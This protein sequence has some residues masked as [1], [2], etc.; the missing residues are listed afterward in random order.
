[1]RTN[2]LAALLAFGFSA[3]G[4]FTFYFPDQFFNLLP[5]YYGSFNIHFVK[6][7]GISFL[8]SGLLLTLSLAYVKWRIPLTLGGILFVLL[9]GL[10]HIQMLINGMASTFIDLA[11]EVIVIIFPSI[12]AVILFLLRIKENHQQNSAK[13]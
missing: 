8:S 3:V 4:L 9:H 10:F 2:I 11:V 13:E 1:M 12:L 5:S 6:D 7:A